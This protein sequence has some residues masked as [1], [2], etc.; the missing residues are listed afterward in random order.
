MPQI[1]LNDIPA[2][3]QDYFIDHL[4]D[5]SSSLRNCALVCHAWT[6]AAQYHLFRSVHVRG[7]HTSVRDLY[8]LLEHSPSI[9]RSVRSLRITDRIQ[10]HGVLAKLIRLLGPD[11]LTALIISAVEGIDTVEH[12][13]W[14]DDLLYA[15]VAMQNLKE[16]RL[17]LKADID[18]SASPDDFLERTTGLSK[19]RSLEIRSLRPSAFSALCKAVVRAKEPTVETYPISHL[20]VSVVPGTTIETA[21]ELG[22]LLGCIG[23][24]LTSL[25][26]DLSPFK[27]PRL[28]RKLN[29]YRLR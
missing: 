10:D 8:T 20:T 7:E 4:H 9:A 29:G 28:P 12:K 24:D 2:E 13:T 19:L 6:P 15:I 11:T 23:R 1:S 16:L 17:Q 21:L 26:L 3:V 25:T 5:D 27:R 14:F 22:L 18:T